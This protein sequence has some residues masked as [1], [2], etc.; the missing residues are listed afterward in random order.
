MTAR[1]DAVSARR[2]NDRPS[3]NEASARKRSFQTACLPVA[4]ASGGI[5]DYI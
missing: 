2:I 1:H 3:E 5:V 4:R